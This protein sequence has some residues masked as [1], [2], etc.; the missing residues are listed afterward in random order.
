MITLQRYDLILL[1]CSYCYSTT[2]SDAH[3]NQSN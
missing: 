2:A 1:L 3:D